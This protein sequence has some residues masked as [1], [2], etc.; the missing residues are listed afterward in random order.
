MPIR[1]RIAMLGF[2]AWVLIGC[3]ASPWQSATFPL[4]Y[5]AHARFSHAGDQ[6]AYEL[7]CS[8]KQGIWIAN[9]D[10]LQARQIQQESLI[11]SPLP[12]PTPRSTVTPSA[13]GWLVPEIAP[14]LSPD[15]QRRETYL[16]PFW[17]PDDTKVAYG[18]LI[19][20]RYFPRGTTIYRQR[21][22]CVSQG[23]KRLCIGTEIYD[24]KTNEHLSLDMVTGASFAPDSQRVALFRHCMYW[25]TED[26]KCVK[27]SPQSAT[28][29][30]LGDAYGLQVLDLRSRQVI[31]S[32]HIFR[33]CFFKTAGIFINRR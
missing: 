17:S 31:F 28:A 4:K 26:R 29:Q 21:L 5:A 15:Y 1:L 16:K 24:L 23:D 30:L 14:T 27:L 9:A 7:G 10:G 20:S 25:Y 3:N 12:C 2:F 22:D 19:D 18:R 13:S 11:N 6:V 32:D 8:E 33:E